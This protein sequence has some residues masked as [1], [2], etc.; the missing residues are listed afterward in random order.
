M[1]LHLVTGYS[2]KAHITSADQGALNAATF[3][4]GNY[5][6]NVGNRLAA[7]VVTNNSINVLDG[8]VIMQG[9]HIRME[10]GAFEEL[11]VENG[12]QEYFRNDLICIRYTKDS[13]TGIEDAALVIIK[14]NPDKSTGVDPAYNNGS[15][16]NGIL[17]VDFPLYRVP[18]NGLNIS[19][20]VPL[21]EAKGSI[22]ERMSAVETGK[23]DKVNG[24]GLST[25][26]YSDAEKQQVATNKSDIENIKNGTTKVGKA[27]EAD[28]AVKTSDS[29]KLGGKGAGE[30]ALTN[31]IT[32]KKMPTGTDLNTCNE[33]G[34]Y[35]F[36][37]YAYNYTNTPNRDAHNGLMSVYRYS[38]DRVEQLYYS[39]NDRRLYTRTM[40]STAATEWFT[41]ATT[42]D[43][44]GYLPNTGGTGTG[45]YTFGDS[46]GTPVT[47]KRTGS[48]GNN[49]IAFEDDVN[50]ITGYLGFFGKDTP[51]YIDSS[52]SRK[53]LIHSG[54]VGDY[55]LP[56]NSPEAKV[57]ID[58]ASTGGNGYFVQSGE[59][60]TIGDKNT[61]TG[62]VRQIVIKGHTE[63]PNDSDALL[64][65][66]YNTNWSSYKLLHSGNVKNYALPI[67]G[68]KLTGQTTVEYANTTLFALNNITAN[69]D[70]AYIR[71]MANSESLGWFGFNGADNPV[72][73]HTDG[74][75]KRSLLH[76]GNSAK[77]LI[78][79]TPLT[80]EG[81]IRVW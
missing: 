26:D 65:Q 16:L 52:I 21:F 3:G 81:S 27:G 76:T 38:V 61:D 23:V 55:A 67:N 51:I 50:G 36:D 33:Q 22:D 45:E 10:S 9:R 20:L 1:A 17:I 39:I 31:Q 11:I 29:D 49:L 28:T 66:C 74:A 6:L 46:G 14:G 80:A 8:E 37:G 60:T 19:T 44:A 47:I 2:G 4:S 56:V 15:I 40:T 43:L 64:F 62:K 70:S 24:K 71:Y 35:Y 73:V 5:V 32:F 63:V 54:N 75:T 53:A 77:V 41:L 18:L 58:V 13:T 59:T 79:S 68:G 57:R 42:A 34:F 12:A 69:A 72:Y 7:R 25:N 48:S 30:Y 78:Q